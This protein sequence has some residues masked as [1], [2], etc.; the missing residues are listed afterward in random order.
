MEPP[1]NQHPISEEEAKRLISGDLG[2]VYRDILKSCCV[3][4][5]WGYYDKIS[6]FKILHN[7][8]LTLVKTPERLLGVTAAHVIQK[9]QEDSKNNNKVILR[10]MNEIIPTLEIIDCNKE[11]DLVTISINKSICDR[12][13]SMRSFGKEVTPL[14]MWPPKVPQESYGIMFAGYPGDDILHSNRELNFGLFTGIDRARTVNHDQITCWIQREDLVIN[15]GGVPTL[16]EN[17][18]FGG[19]SGGP[20]ISWF[21]N[22]ITYYCL[23]GI[24][25]QAYGDGDYIIAKRAD[26]IR[27]DGSIRLS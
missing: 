16:P 4:I 7:G 5:F 24:I 13:T 26:F 6:N 20:L 25:S 21:K 23:S 9:Y 11:L 2:N 27:P 12:N 19:M 22:Y 3:P 1:S 8:T 17:Y 15:S 14:E 10:L 18:N